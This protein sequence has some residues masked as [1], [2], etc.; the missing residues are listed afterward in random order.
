MITTDIIDAARSC[1][2]TPFKHQGRI[3]GRSLDCAG[4]V[5][6]VGRDVGVDLTDVIGYGRNPTGQLL[7]SALDS[8]PELVR[9]VNIH[10]R[11]AGDI[12]LMRFDGEP[13]HLAIFEG[14]NI[15]HSYA[16]VQKACEHLLTDE[17][18]NRIVRVYRFKGL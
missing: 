13:Q 10:N 12:L 5:I 1:L 3:K 9:I 11:Q 2:G 7:E 15:I 18:A 14:T 17:W 4:L 8:Q 16:A 6:T